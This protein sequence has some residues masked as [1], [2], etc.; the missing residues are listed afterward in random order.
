MDGVGGRV[1]VE[2]HETETKTQ[3]YFGKKTNSKFLSRTSTDYTFP[4]SVRLFGFCA[5]KNSVS[6]LC[7][8]FF[9]LFFSKNSVSLYC[10]LFPSIDAFLL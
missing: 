6:V 7:I 4:L 5:Q 2:I 9:Y 10:P 8:I 3:K 1:K